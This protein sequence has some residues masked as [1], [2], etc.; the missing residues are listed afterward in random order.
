MTRCATRDSG[1]AG[2]ARYPRERAEELPPE[3]SVSTLTS[4]VSIEFRYVVVDHELWALGEMLKVLEPAITRAGD[5][6]ETSRFEELSRSGWEADDAER[7][8][9]SQDVYEMRRSIL[10]R[11]IRGPFVV[12]LWA[13]FEG[14]VTSIAAEKSVEVQAEIQLFELKGA[15]LQRARRYFGAVLGVPFTIDPERT[16]RLMALYSVRNAFAHSNG[17]KE[18]VS[19]EQ[20]RALEERL[21]RVMFDSSGTMLILSREY[22]EAAYEDVS[23]SLNDLLAAARATRRRRPR[24]AR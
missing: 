18:G 1:L 8:F 6:Y 23:E 9:A 24:P 20:W 2:L 21:D 13:T 12:A 14:G 4:R 3:A 22:L 17:R 19:D 16:Q 5:L 15:F 10:P 7:S 11:L